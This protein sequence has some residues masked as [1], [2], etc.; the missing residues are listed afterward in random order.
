MFMH[1]NDFEYS[2]AEKLLCM[3]TAMVGV[4]VA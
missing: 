1:A 3:L 4:L 2:I